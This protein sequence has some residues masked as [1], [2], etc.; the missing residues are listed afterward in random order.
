MA[1]KLLKSLQGVGERLVATRGDMSKA[2]QIMPTMISVLWAGPI[3]ESPEIDEIRQMMSGFYGPGINKCLEQGDQVD[4]ELQALFKNLMPTP[5]QIN[6]YFRQFCDKY[7][8]D[9]EKFSTHL[10]ISVQLTS[11]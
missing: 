2:I 3:L 1:T 6:T 5:Q 10:H 7:D 9:I 8:I 11:T 4:A